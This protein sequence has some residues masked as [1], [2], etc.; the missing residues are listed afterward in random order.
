MAKELDEAELGQVAGSLI[1]STQPGQ[2][3]GAAMAN[4]LVQ[5]GAAAMAAGGAAVASTAAVLV[6]AAPFLAVGAICY[7]IVKAFEKA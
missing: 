6:T 2:A 5:G 7:G 4:T 1:M 3:L